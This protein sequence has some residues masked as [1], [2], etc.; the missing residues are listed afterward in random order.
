MV[1]A[2][3]PL[4]WIQYPKRSIM[5]VKLGRNSGFWLQHMPIM[6][7]TWGGQFAGA[8]NLAPRATQVITSRLRMPVYGIN[9]ND[10]TSHKSTPKDLLRREN[11]N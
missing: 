9:P 8:P 1:S 4:T 6:A 7:N 11:N 2:W 3:G 5:V 10:I